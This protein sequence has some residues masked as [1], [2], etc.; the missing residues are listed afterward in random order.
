MERSRDMEAHLRPLSPLQGSPEEELEGRSG[1]FDR[2]PQERAGCGR[3]SPN[4]TEHMHQTYTEK[5]LGPEIPRRMQVPTPVQLCASQGPQTA[6]VLTSAKEHGCARSRALKSLEAPL[7]HVKPLN[8]PGN[9][10]ARHACGGLSSESFPDAMQPPIAIHGP[11]GENGMSQACRS[12]PGLHSSMVHGNSLTPSCC[13]P[14][15]DLPAADPAG[16]SSETAPEGSTWAINKAGEAPAALH[17]NE[18][19]V[20]GSRGLIG[21]SRGEIHERKHLCGPSHFVVTNSLPAVGR[22][23]K[24]MGGARVASTTSRQN[25]PTSPR[26]SAWCLQ[27]GAGAPSPASAANRGRFSPNML[28]TAGSR[29]TR[30]QTA[31][32]ALNEVVRIED[33][34][35]EEAGRG[36]THEHG[37][38]SA[39]ADQGNCHSTVEAANGR[40]PLNPLSGLS[41]GVMGGRTEAAAAFLVFVAALVRPDGHGCVL[42]AEVLSR[43]AAESAVVQPHQQRRSCREEASTSA[44][45]AKGAAPHRLDGDGCAAKGVLVLQADPEDGCVSLDLWHPPPEPALKV[46]EAGQKLHAEAAL[47]KPVEL[48]SS[49][50]VSLLCFP[51][52]LISHFRWLGLG[53]AASLPS[54]LKSEADGE[55]GTAGG[56]SCCSRAVCC[57]CCR[58]STTDRRRMCAKDKDRNHAIAHTTMPGDKPG[59]GQTGVGRPHCRGDRLNLQTIVDHSCSHRGEN[60]VPPASGLFA[61]KSVAVAMRRSPSAEATQPISA[62]PREGTSTAKSDASVAGEYERH[63]TMKKKRSS[64]RSGPKHSGSKEHERVGQALEKRSSG[65]HHRRQCRSSSASRPSSSTQIKPSQNCRREGRERPIREEG[66]VPQGNGTKS[67]SSHPLSVE[68]KEQIHGIST[69]RNALIVTDG[70]PLHGR[71]L[72]QSDVAS[73]PSCTSTHFESKRDDTAKKNKRDSSSNRY[74]TSGSAEEKDM[75]RQ[76]HLGEGPSTFGSLLALG[77]TRSKEQQT[78][79]KG[80]PREHLPVREL[81]P[82][83][84]SAHDSKL[85]YGR[86]LS[87]SECRKASGCHASSQDGHAVP[88]LCLELQQSQANKLYCSDLLQK[89]LDQEWRNSMRCVASSLQEG[90]LTGGN[91]PD[92]ICRSSSEIPDPQKPIAHTNSSGHGRPHTKIERSSRDSKRRGRSDS[93][94]RASSPSIN[95]NSFEGSSSVS[96]GST[97][98]IK[99]ANG[100]CH[101]SGESPAEGSNGHSDRPRSSTGKRSSRTRSSTTKHERSSSSRRRCRSS[102]SRRKKLR[103][104]VSFSSTV[105]AT[106]AGC[107]KEVCHSPVKESLPQRDVCCDGT[108]GSSSTQLVYRNIASSNIN[109]TE[110][111]AC[112]HLHFLDGSSTEI[113]NSAPALEPSIT[114]EKPSLAIKT[115]DES[116]LST[117]MESSKKRGPWLLLCIGPA[118][119]VTPSAENSTTAGEGDQSDSHLVEAAPVVQSVCRSTHED[120]TGNG[121]GTKLRLCEAEVPAY[122]R[123]DFLSLFQVLLPSNPVSGAFFDR[124]RGTGLAC[125]PTNVA[126]LLAFF[127]GCIA[128]H[129]EAPSENQENSGQELPK[130]QPHVSKVLHKF[131]MSS[132][133]PWK[134]LCKGRRAISSFSIERLVSCWSARGRRAAVDSSIPGGSEDPTNLPCDPAAPV[135]RSALPIADIKGQAPARPA[136]AG[137]PPVFDLLLDER[138]LRRLSEK[139]FLDD[140]IIDFCLGFIVDHILTPEERLRVHISNTFFLSALMEQRCEMEAHTRLTRWLK[141]ELTP[142]PKKDFIFIPVHHKH[143]HW[144]LAVVVYPWRAINPSQTNAEGGTVRTA[145]NSVSKPEISKPLDDVQQLYP[146]DMPTHQPGINGSPKSLAIG[147]VAPSLTAKCRG[148]DVAHASASLKASGQHAQKPSRQ[149]AR[150]FH[151]DSMGLRSV[152]DRCRGR[153]KRFLRQ[154]FEHRCAGELKSGERVELCTDSC[155]WHDGHSCT[156]HTPRQQNGYDCGVFVIEYVYFLTRN[157]NAIE[158]LLVGPSRDCQLQQRYA[159]QPAAGS[160]TPSTYGCLGRVD[161]T[162]ETKRQ[163]K[164]LEAALGFHCP[165]MEAALPSQLPIGAGSAFGLPY[166]LKA[167]LAEL[168]QAHAA[169]FGSSNT[170]ISRQRELQLQASVQP[171][172]PGASQGNGASQEFTPQPAEKTRFS[173]RPR[174]APGLHGRQDLTAVIQLPDT[175]I[176]D[177]R[178]ASKQ[179]CPAWGPLPLC[180]SKRRSS[181]TKWFSQNRVTERRSQLHKML[182]FMRQNMYWREDPKLIAH[183]KSVFLSIDNS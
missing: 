146:L 135:S 14:G 77:S 34:S 62:L 130:G 106:A 180:I 75:E 96:S 142:L 69:P 76:Q 112:Q 12:A 139:E 61:L 158:T 125:E 72:P 90:Q 78:K 67:H 86:S 168:R 46:S 159:Q 174:E 126:D 49:S 5:E 98:D 103:R 128:E 161:A 53:G 149:K 93:S 95:G 143:Q 88:V 175:H 123:D 38:H 110:G 101:A 10:V 104:E 18:L 134:A 26:S 162:V 133:G 71:L 108:A 80:A 173:M 41:R 150:L 136:P 97:K 40:L 115:I 43:V 32:A 141:K 102:S 152:F 171:T 160:I 182:L 83:V 25:D 165:C 169:L 107:R 178:A 148:V 65:G 179:Q 6:A 105:A 19:L 170:L 21:S 82:E 70:K 35:D 39:E 27:T 137:S 51:K 57:C 120:K 36:V 124:F 81:G 42:S 13:S 163:G 29:V 114:G 113:A 181:H 176:T 127:T 121:S 2:H 157:L 8:S 23:S 177:G 48:P 100:H 56:W 50:I 55:K 99:I 140:T 64:T 4:C 172:P 138:T 73:S 131:L 15:T 117:P 145:E 74:G 122:C 167:R 45:E 17:R 66:S 154:E 85:H 183:L 60:S 155:C 28:S 166:N 79:E 116:S 109:F 20:G 147:R 111:G 59:E 68:K 94:N 11:R 44:A 119:H 1:L 9:F 87:C 37:I 16:R 118:L 129:K 156:L 30:S 91:S 153:L 144:S 63:I 33:S 92:A 164:L 151:V 84:A 58:G 7:Q 31:A 3:F 89:V 24:E 52:S 22:R 47:G 132:I 54:V